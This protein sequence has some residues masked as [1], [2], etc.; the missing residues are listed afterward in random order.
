MKKVGLLLMIAFIS[1]SISA[2]NYE[3]KVKINGISDTVVYLGHHFG[4]KKY[5]ID[6]T[7]IDSKGYAVFS[8]NENL[9]RGIYIIVMPSKN[10][11][12]F[13]ILIADQKK[14]SIEKKNVQAMRK[15]LTLT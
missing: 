1:L 3:I 12:Y 2:Q 4:E 11:T 14:F 13:E 9:N 6:T 5:V 7:R 8:G 10:M 15:K